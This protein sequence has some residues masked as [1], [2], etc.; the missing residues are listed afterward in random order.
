MKKIILLSIILIFLTGCSGLYN[1]GNFV[2]PD[3]IEFLALIEELDTPKK[4]CQYMLD[5]FGIEE[6]PYNTLTP[7]ELYRIKKGDCDD[8]SNFSR[9]M[10]N[11]HGIETYQILMFFP[12][13][14]YS[15]DVWHAITIY[16]EDDCYTFSE[17]Q[18]YNPCNKYYNSFSEIM[19]IFNGWK[20]YIVYDYYNNIMETGYNN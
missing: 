17:N 8:F 15:I 18:Y 12:K 14:I 10:A 20:K 3:D 13:P 6:H 2:L 9:F 5:N 7:Y 16:K 19:Q 1:L 4:I 11:Q